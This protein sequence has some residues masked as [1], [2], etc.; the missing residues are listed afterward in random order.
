[1]NAQFDLKERDIRIQGLMN[2]LLGMQSS[3]DDF[4]PPK[5]RGFPDGDFVP[6]EPHAEM[7]GESSLLRRK[8]EKYEDD[9]MNHKLD[10]ERL[11]SEKLEAE[12][13]GKGF[14]ERY[15]LQCVSMPSVAWRR[16]IWRARQ[17]RICVRRLTVQ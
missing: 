12:V 9:I 8:I 7:K 1:V 17:G 10:I 6:K 13:A 14:M 15:V 11:Q 2:K 16:L 5:A 4:S 3:L